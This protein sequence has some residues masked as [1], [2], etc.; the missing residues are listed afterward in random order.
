MSFFIKPGE[1]IYL[2]ANIAFKN[3]LVKAFVR[4][5]RVKHR[6]EDLDRLV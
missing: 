6:K 4:N 5:F 1:T 2:S 3:I